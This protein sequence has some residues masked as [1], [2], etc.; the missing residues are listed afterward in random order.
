MKKTFCSLSP[1]S[2]AELATAYEDIN[3]IINLKKKVENI[4]WQ[5]GS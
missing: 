1:H 2:A 5:T 4:P 3:E